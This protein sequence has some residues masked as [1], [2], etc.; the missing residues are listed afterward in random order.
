MTRR[1]YLEV[2][3]SEHRP[4]LVVPMWPALVVALLVA[5]LPFVIGAF[6]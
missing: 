5:V 1:R 4:P 2:W 3:T 6:W